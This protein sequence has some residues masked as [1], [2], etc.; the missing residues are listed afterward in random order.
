MSPCAYGLM[1]IR[2]NLKTGEPM[3]CLMDRNRPEFLATVKGLT[4]EEIN[5]LGQ[6]D[7]LDLASGEGH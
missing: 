3:L 2:D 4:D 5:K 6:E 1:E 7:S